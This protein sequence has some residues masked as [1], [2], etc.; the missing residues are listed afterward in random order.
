M[1]FADAEFVIRFRPFT[2]L[3]RGGFSMGAIAPTGLRKVLLMHIAFASTV[4]KKYRIFEIQKKLQPRFKIP[5][6]SPVKNK[7]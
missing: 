4:L 3:N 2:N 5:N 6:T 7:N 1:K